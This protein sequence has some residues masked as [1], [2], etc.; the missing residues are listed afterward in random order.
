[1][2]DC[3]GSLEVGKDADFIVV[4]PVQVDPAAGERPSEP[5]SDVLSRLL[6]RSDPRM[7]MATFVRGKRCFNREA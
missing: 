1:M 5:A 3:I 2:A 7:V 6:Y 4:D